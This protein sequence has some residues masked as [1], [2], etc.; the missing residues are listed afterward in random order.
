MATNLYGISAYQQT[1]QTWKK[2]NT[3]EEK[4]EKAK[5]AE[6]SKAEK[7]D[8]SGKT[9]ETS[10]TE[11]KV[12]KPIDPKGSLVSVQKEGYGMVIGDVN[13]SDEAKEYYNKLKQKFHNSDFI[14]VSKDMKSQV[15][16]NAS[17]YA[18]PN[19]LV[20]L[21][22]EEK[23]ERMAADPSYRDKYE[24]IIAMAELQMAQAGNSIPSSGAAVKNY[25]MSV[26]ANGTL[27]YFAVLEKAS[28]D[29][30]ERIAKKAEERAEE[31]VKEKKQAEKEEKEKRLE[32]SEE[33]EYI[34][35][36]A[37]SLEEL[38]R[39]LQSYAY[40]NSAKNV[41]TEAEKAVGQN[42]DLRG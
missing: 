8:T 30:K 1:N 25:G 39:K 19:K 16:Q 41:M 22:D 35:I 40:A 42:F 31:K 10:K 27:K 26:D 18:N 32:E 38:L 13:L 5:S 29:Q 15:E 33:K 7:A 24:G 14:L 34:E 21:I 20:V 11:E 17:A 12:W 36:E 23:I 6:A 4:T 28:A 2:A 9:S 3:K 37:D